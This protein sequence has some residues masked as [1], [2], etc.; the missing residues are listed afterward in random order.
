MGRRRRERPKR[1]AV[2]L[3]QIRDRLGLS[4]T[5]MIRAMGLEDRLTKSEIS[6]FER[7]THEPS[8]LLL[9]SYC[10]AANIY[11]EAL[12]RDGMDLPVKLPATKKHQGIPQSSSK[13]PRK[14]T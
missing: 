9:L 11:L 7:G 2:K 5:G 3:R 12:V 8:L 10:E 13:K 6:A 4:Q 1:L 14:S